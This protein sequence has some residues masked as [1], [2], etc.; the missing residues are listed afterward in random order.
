M[1]WFGLACSRWCQSLVETKGRLRLLGLG[2][3]SEMRRSVRFRADLG[4]LSV[5]P[6]LGPLTRAAL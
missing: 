5:G 3:V 2:T 6:A 1:N 4:I